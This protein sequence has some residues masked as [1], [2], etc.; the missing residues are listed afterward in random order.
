ML[1]H[2]FNFIENFNVIPA[3]RNDFLLQKGTQQNSAVISLRNSLDGP[4]EIHLELTISF[5]TNNS[6]IGIYKANLIIY[7]SQYYPQKRINHFFLLNK[8]F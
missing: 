7:V 8:K 5:L 4:Q 1:K 2:L 3:V 6:F